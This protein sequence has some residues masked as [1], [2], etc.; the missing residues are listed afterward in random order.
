MN[1]QYYGHSC[2]KITTK[3]SGRNTENVVVFIDPFDKKIGLKPPQGGADVV[4]VSHTQHSD[5]N[6]VSALKGDPIIVDTPGEFSVK[7]I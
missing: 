6:N 4:F 2:F 7:G 5:H 3:P 1:I